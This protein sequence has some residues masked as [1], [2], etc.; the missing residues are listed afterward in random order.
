MNKKSFN[1]K[2]YLILCFVAVF[3][4]SIKNV[5]ARGRVTVPYTNAPATNTYSPFAPLASSA[6]TDDEEEY[7]EESEYPQE[8]Y[9]SSKGKRLAKKCAARYCE[10]F[11]N[12][13]GKCFDTSAA[14]SLLSS[15][16]EEEMEESG[17]GTR[18]LYDFLNDMNRTFLSACGNINSDFTD[19]E[20][21]AGAKD[22]KSSHRVKYLYKK[23]RVNTSESELDILDWDVEVSET[24]NQD[25]SVVV[26]DC[27]DL[28]TSSETPSYVYQDQYCIDL[29][30][31]AIKPEISSGSVTCPS[32]H[33]TLQNY[34]TQSAINSCEKK[35]FAY[36]SDGLYKYERLTSYR[37]ASGKCPVYVGYGPLQNSATTSEGVRIGKGKYFP[38]K[39]FLGQNSRMTCSR[40]NF[41]LSEEKMTYKVKMKHDAAA[42]SQLINGSVDVLIGG[43]GA[44]TAGVKASEVKE[45]AFMEGEM[46]DKI[47][48]PKTAESCAKN[49][50]MCLDESGDVV[51]CHTEITGEGETKDFSKAKA[52]PAQMKEFKEALMEAGNIDDIDDNIEI[53]N[54]GWIER[55]S[56][57][58]TS[59]W[60][61]N[62]TQC[63]MEKKGLISFRKNIGNDTTKKIKK[64][65]KA[66]I[67]DETECSS[68][69]GKWVSFEDSYTGQQMALNK[70]LKDANTS[71]Y[72]NADEIC[73]NGE[74]SALTEMMKTQAKWQTKFRDSGYKNDD[75]GVL[76]AK[77]AYKGAASVYQACIEMYS[78]SRGRLAASKGRY[79]ILEEQTWDEG[80]P[81]TYDD[82][83]ENLISLSKEQCEKVDPF[84]IIQTVVVAKSAGYNIV[85]TEDGADDFLK[86]YKQRYAEKC[87]D[88]EETFTGFNEC[89]DNLKDD[90]EFQSE[91]SDM[92]MMLAIYQQDYKKDM[93]RVKAA[94]Q[95]LTDLEKNKKGY[96][97]AISSARDGR[98]D[99]LNNVMQG[100]LQITQAVMQNSYNKE[101]IEGKCVITNKNAT[102]VE[103]VI[104]NEGERIKLEY[105][106]F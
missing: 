9:S 10:G 6:S 89:I 47:A 16:C 71:L 26:S 40:E 93:A 55:E 44:A 96:S 94:K 4:F 17:H 62:V 86:L 97:S 53:V 90:T 31:V 60:N 12:P 29:R 77:N 14:Y 11:G 7:E 27:P 1:L 28:D 57:N 32:S 85:C 37:D 103:G 42:M 65:K 30:G 52:T 59:L 68:I 92:K 25:E 82:D 99:S 43:V 66:Y 22:K 74:A 49:G 8:D 61:N 35:M 70:E 78:G 50:Y 46:C 100:G 72:G 33:P 18:A 39:V 21:F 88:K 5:I 76:E 73:R 83:L 2:M 101:L 56:V 102:S 48:R 79:D 54:R 67:Y 105:D 41:N 3:A 87:A 91:L 13:Y 75:A 38:L 84:R 64:A 20:L 24:L 95:G 58:K 36:G 104:A 45:K 106:M 80:Q 98:K 81:T 63:G 19:E 69:G 23:A 34:T 51:A 15:S